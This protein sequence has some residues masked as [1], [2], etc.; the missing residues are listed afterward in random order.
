MSTVVIIFSLYMKEERIR[1]SSITVIFLECC[2]HMSRYGEFNPFIS[3][4]FLNFFRFYILDKKIPLLTMEE[5][6]KQ[7][8]KENIKNY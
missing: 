8:G 7:E 1:M 3:F 4:I 2:I 6:T 5:H